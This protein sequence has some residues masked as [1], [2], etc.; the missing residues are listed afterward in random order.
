MGL[1]LGPNFSR[2]PHAAGFSPYQSYVSSPAPNSTTR[3]FVED[4]LPAA[5]AGGF[6]AHLGRDHRNDADDLRLRC[7]PVRIEVVG[8]PG[9]VFVA[10]GR[11]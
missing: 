2:P 7:E 3:E 9:K 5:L 8:R 4:A 10:C 11:G 6:P 1:A